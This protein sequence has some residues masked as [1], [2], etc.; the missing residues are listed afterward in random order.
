[1]SPARRKSQSEKA[2]PKIRKRV[3]EHID[4][5]GFQRV[6]D[7]ESWCREHEFKVSV[8]KTRSDLEAE[9][10]IFD[11]EARV[12]R[13]HTRL[14][15]KPRRAIEAVCRGEVAATDIPSPKLR[16]VCEPIERS[17]KTPG[18][19]E[20]LCELLLLVDRKADFLY[21]KTTFGNERL[22]FVKALIALNDRRS[23]WL[24][25]VGEWALTSHNARKQFSSLARHLMA[26]YQ[27]PQFMDS[28]WFW[29]SP[30]GYRYRDWFVLIGR[31]GNIRTT[32]API[33]LTKKIVHHFFQAPD[34]YTVEGALRW[35]QVHSLGG[36]R[37]LADAILATQ[38]GRSFENEDFWFT[39]IRFFANNPMLD[40][41]HVGP[42]VD[43]LQNQRFEPQ[44]VF[45]APGVREERPPPQPNLSMHGRSPDT[46][47]RQVDA[48]HDRL[49]KVRRA[50][51]FQWERSN[52]RPFEFETR[53]SHKILKIWRIRELLSSSELAAEGLA[54]QHCVYSYAHSCK[55]GRCSIW[56]MEVESHT[57][58]EKRQTIEV[59]NHGVIVQS[60]GKRNAHPTAQELEVLHRWAQKAKLQVS[61]YLRVD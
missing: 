1:M 34:D 17:K 40:R 23:Q 29:R 22:E 51:D 18:A 13:M 49:G 47:L 44:H 15:R 54:M 28:V 42:V 2:A 50:G 53:A 59:N 26:R 6:P 10:K 19:R 43:F 39:V 5:L 45:T 27:V 3:L 4:T 35:G 33:L 31:G 30:G 8:D 57:G 16:A 48:W 12:R 61:S 32:K 60:R 7:Y 55:A 56:T 24:R 20:S 41:S 58:D 36:R 9:K 52:I 21:D 46:L 25:P 38:L 11:Q 37:R 14:A